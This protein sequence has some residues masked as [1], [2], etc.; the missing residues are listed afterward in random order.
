MYCPN[1]GATVQKSE[2]F[3]TICGAKLTTN[4]TM[5][6]TIKLHCSNC[7]GTMDVSTDRSVLLCPYCGSKELIQE[8]E[9]VQIER[10][11]Q[12][13]VLLLNDQNLKAQEEDRE[14]IIQLEKI[15]NRQR[16]RE[17]FFDTIQSISERRHEREMIK[18]ERELLEEEKRLQNR[19]E[20]NNSSSGCCLV[21]L[22]ILPF[23]IMFYF[24]FWPFI[25]LYKFFKWLF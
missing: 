23:K 15:K 19:R 8:S 5:K 9:Q 1:C 13:T 17:Q 25:L 16:N 6:N 11:K 2:K 7:G 4:E 14:R 3:C 22:F 18:R 20:E 12:N 21:S 24:C 10:I